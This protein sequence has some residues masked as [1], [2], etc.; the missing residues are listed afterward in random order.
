MTHDT[1]CTPHER[2][3]HAQLYLHSSGRWIPPRGLYD[4]LEIPL[5]ALSESGPTLTP[6]ATQRAAAYKY[7]AQDPI[8]LSIC[9]VKKGLPSHSDSGD[10]D[11]ADNP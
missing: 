7:L 8:R 3:L 2:Q 1:K 5:L 10:M 6:A 4:I 9:V 11:H